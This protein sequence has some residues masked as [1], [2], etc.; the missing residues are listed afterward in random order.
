MTAWR[1]VAGLT[2]GEDLKRL[3]EDTWSGVRLCG[4]SGAV[5]REL[6]VR[7][8]G[9]RRMSAAS[10]SA[11]LRVPTSLR[12]RAASAAHSGARRHLLSS[13]L[14]HRISPQELGDQTRYSDWT[15]RFFCVRY[16][17]SLSTVKSTDHCVGGPKIV[18]MTMARRRLPTGRSHGMTA[19]SA[20]GVTAPVWAS[21]EAE[22]FSDDARLAGRP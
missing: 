7:V 13:F 19:L 20:T 6:L 2:R 21:K 8:P 17:S 9:V 1:R 4:F 11:A 10:G 15:T 16:V 14:R 12:W 22:L 18:A 3:L 5:G